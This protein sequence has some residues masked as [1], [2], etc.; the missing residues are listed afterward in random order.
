MTRQVPS[1]AERASR[2]MFVALAVST[3]FAFGLLVY[4]VSVMIE[5]MRTELGWSNAALSAGPTV[6]LAVSGL[7]AP[8]VGRSI[9]LHG[10]RRLM[11]IGS[12]VGGIGVLV[13]S[14]AT[15]YGIYLGAW[16]IIGIGMA[17]SVY[18]PA[19]ATIV[20][21]APGRRRQGILVVTLVGALASTIFIPIAALL[22]HQFG[23]RPALVLLAL[24]HVV[25]TVPICLLG[26]PRRGSIVAPEHDPT[27]STT[28]GPEEDGA[29]ASST[30]RTASLDA[31]ATPSVAPT[32]SD[33][34]QLRRIVVANVLGGSA[35]V[36]V[37]VHLV[38]YLVST[39]RTPGRAA[40]IAG[41]L[42]IAKVAGRLAVGAAAKHRESRAL[43]VL[44]LAVMGAGLALPLVVPS[45][46]TEVIM[47][48]AFGAA[49]GGKTVLLPLFIAEQ[50]GS[51]VFGL[52]SGRVT[53]IGKLSFAFAPLAAGALVT[54]SASYTPTWAALAAGCLLA[55]VTLLASPS[56]TRATA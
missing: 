4:T 21:H 6:G 49:A 38:A 41:L 30:P 43:L 53:R 40:A 20:R 15:S 13:W 19:F 44:C 26:V 34:P 51:Q 25:V 42:G 5:P 2:P 36:A 55:A 56:A 24:A 22:V 46:T 12:V 27:G 1:T 52:A 23:W 35:N 16:T 45:G 31:R 48:V 29:R 14:S 18:E 9:D 33:S 37:G 11:A 7:L 54:L 17:M 39:G 3:T 10:G 32:L 47:V 8:L 28:A 50:F